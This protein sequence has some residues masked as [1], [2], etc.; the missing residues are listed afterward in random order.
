MARSNIH[1][2]WQRLDALGMAA[3]I[4][5]NRLLAQYRRGFWIIPKRR[6]NLRD[7]G[8]GRVRLHHHLLPQ[9]PPG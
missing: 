6:P 7:H 2:L 9:D 3:A 5:E 8:C 4:P 1:L